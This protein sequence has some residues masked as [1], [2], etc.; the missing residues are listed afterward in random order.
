[1]REGGIL[2]VH[3]YYTCYFYEFSCEPDIYVNRVDG[4][5]IK[6]GYSFNH[7]KYYKIDQI[8]YKD[9]YVETGIRLNFICEGEYNYISVFHLMKVIALAFAFL[10]FPF[11]L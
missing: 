3:L 1:M 11:Y 9:S 8:E 7:T 4:K 2:N 5:F 6:K 10:Y